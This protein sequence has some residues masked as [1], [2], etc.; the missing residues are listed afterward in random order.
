MAVIQASALGDLVA[1]T[2]PDL[3][4]LRLTEIAT[5]VQDHIVSRVL[6]KQNRVELQSGDY[7]TFRV[8]TDHNHSAQTVGLY[9]RDDLQKRDGIITATLQWRHTTANYVIDGRELAMNRTPRRII[10]L[11]KDERIKCL[12]SMVELFEQ[13]FWTATNATTG[14]NDPLGLPYFI[15]KNATTGFNGGILTGWP[16]CCGISPT[17]YPRWNNWSDIYTSV[18]FDDLITKWRTAKRKTNF[19]PPVDGIPT[20]NTGDQ[21]GWYTNSDTLTALE[22]L[23]TSQ[24]EDLGNDLASRD[25]QAIF[26][27]LPITYVPWLDRDSTNPIYG[28]NWGLFKWLVLRGWWMRETVIP[29][30]A[31]MHTVSSQHIDC[32][33]QPV[34]RDRRRQMVLATSASYPS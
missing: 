3:G 18:S 24:N 32:T 17:T 29:I 6:M 15:T 26:H 34:C 28:I 31:D 1:S 2:L 25:G 5:D 16:D 8:L 12:I 20:F 14:A 33:Y 19:R 7:A 11:L 9:Q 27:R 10:D 22:S 23:V 13:L 30:R 4:E 21:Y